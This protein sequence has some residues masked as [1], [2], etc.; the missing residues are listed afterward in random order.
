MLAVLF[1]FFNRLLFLPLN[2]TQTL[3]PVLV[4]AQAVLLLPAGYIMKQGWPRRVF[5]LIAAVVAGYLC[6]NG[7]WQ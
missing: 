6:C 1:I 2:P 3:L 4:A 7:G 5:L